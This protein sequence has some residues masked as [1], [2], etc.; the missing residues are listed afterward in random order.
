M[1]LALVMGHSMK[2]A[3][4]YLHLSEVDPRRPAVN[5][6]KDHHEVAA[7]MQ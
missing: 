2:Q 6:G 7:W 5:L 3:V 1:N 4:Q